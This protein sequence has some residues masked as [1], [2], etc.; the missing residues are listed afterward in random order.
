MN[1]P[2]ALLCVLLLGGLYFGATMP[3]NGD[4]ASAEKR[5][6]NLEKKKVQAFE[7]FNNIEEQTKAVTTTQKDVLQRVPKNPEQEQI[8]RDLQKIAKTTG[9]QFTQ[10]AFTKEQNR[11]VGANELRANFTVEGPAEKML[12]FLRAIE[13][14]QRFMGMET[15]NV[16]LSSRGALPMAALSV[17]LYSVYQ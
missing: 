17:S 3:L 8:L 13:N 12:Q 11:D 5:I 16:Q 7:E 2:L 10:V 4:I 9:Y 1:R 6:Q 14:N 15:L